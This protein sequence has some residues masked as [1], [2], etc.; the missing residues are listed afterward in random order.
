MT[1]IL[2][3]VIKRDAHQRRERAVAVARRAVAALAAVGVDVMVVGSLARGTFRH[4]S[5]IDLLV[6]SC[7][8]ELRYAIEGMVEEEAGGL[9]FDVINLDEVT[10]A[11][12]GRLLSEARRASDLR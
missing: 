2:D 12:R 9:P 11:R 3:S 1:T 8:S 5:D 6:V 10:Q 7:P 4:H